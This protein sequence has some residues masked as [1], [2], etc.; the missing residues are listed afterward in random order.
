M[1]NKNK[2]TLEELG[3]AA[4][5]LVEKAADA[6]LELFEEK[7]MNRGQA[8]AELIYHATQAKRALNPSCAQPPP[9]GSTDDD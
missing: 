1:S 7:G 3:V 4:E 6:L 5:A 8:Y 9:K 2:Q